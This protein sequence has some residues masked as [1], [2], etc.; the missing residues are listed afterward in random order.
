MTR[1]R[2][3]LPAPLHAQV[4]LSFVTGYLDPELNLLVM[5][6]RLIASRY[7]RSWFPL[8]LLSSLPFDFFVF[9]ATSSSMRP[10]VA[11]NAS[12]HGAAAQQETVNLQFL[13]AL[14]LIKVLRIMKLTS[15]ATSE[16]DARWPWFSI[17]PGAADSAQPAHAG[18]SWLAM[19]LISSPDRAAVRVT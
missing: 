16:T 4:C 13:K 8:E 6:H 12:L 3:A 9:L 7:L 5:S 1:A 17:G 2:A 14:R 19:E 11:L 10:D 18:S 15:V